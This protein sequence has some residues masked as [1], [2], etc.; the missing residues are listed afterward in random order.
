MKKTILFLCVAVSALLMTS[1]LGDT[2]NNYRDA[3]FVYIDRDSRGQ[4]YGKAINP[5][6]GSLR[7]ITHS[8]MM[9]MIPGDIKIMTFNWD[10]EYGFTPITYPD[11]SFNADNVNI[12]DEPIDVPRTYID[13]EQISDDEKGKFGLNE[14][15]SPLFSNDKGLLNDYW[16]F[17]YS[18]IA[19]KGERGHVEFYKRDEPNTAGEIVID[20]HFT[21]TGTPE[22][23]NKINN[24]AAV[25]VDMS[26]LRS[27]MS[28]SDKPLKIRFKYYRQRTTGT[29]L[30]ETELQNVITW[31][32]TSK[33]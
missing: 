26:Q 12:L 27:I 14:L 33:N 4:V 18:Y 23:E 1:C 6:Y 28:S 13:L 25:A 3:G 8:S 15:A 30:E 20:V 10:E 16:I 31:D 5:A 22:G 2:S 7:Y 29:D 9:T 17:Q 11:G 32:I 21:L 24:S 19:K